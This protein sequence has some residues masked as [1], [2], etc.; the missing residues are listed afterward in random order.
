MDIKEMTVEQ[1]MVMAYK[2]GRKFE[3]ARQNLNILNQA[4]REKENEQLPE[5]QEPVQEEPTD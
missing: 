3:T 4:I 1:L 2:E 5:L